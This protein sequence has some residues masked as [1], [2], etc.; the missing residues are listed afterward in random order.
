PPPHPPTAPRRAHPRD[1]RVTGVHSFDIHLCIVVLESDKATVEVTVPDIGVRS[2]ER[3][4]GK[5]C[6]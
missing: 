5:E 1:Y 2:E 6:T 4:V 3:I